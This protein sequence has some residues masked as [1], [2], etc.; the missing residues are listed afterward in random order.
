MIIGL[1]SP[2]IAS[3]IEE[4]LDKIKQFLSEAS[5]QG[6]DCYRLMIGITA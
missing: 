5:G 3:S 4:G 2:R 6:A 1:A